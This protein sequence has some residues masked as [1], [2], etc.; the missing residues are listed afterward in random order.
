M[1]LAERPPV[2]RIGPGIHA[3]VV[4][5]RPSP[6][7]SSGVAVLVIL[8]AASMAACSPTVSP[9]SDVSPSGTGTLPSSAAATAPP[10]PG[11]ELYG[12]VPYWEMDD[13][14]AAHLAATPLTTLALF[15]VTHTSKGALSTS[16]NGYRRMTSALG[17]Q[18]IREAHDR[19]TRVELVYSSFGATRNRKLLES[20]SLQ[21]RVIESLVGLVDDLGADGVNV[22]IETLDPILV[23]A[24]GSFVGQLRAAIRAADPDHRVTAATAAGPLGAA[25]AVAAA[26]AGADRIFLMGYDYRVASSSPGATAPLE[27][28][29]G[30]TRDLRW[31][32]DLYAALGVPADRLLLGLP[33][34]GITW[35]VAGPVVGAP[36]TGRGDAWVPRRHLDLLLGAGAGTAVLDP[37]E[38]VDVYFTASDGTVGPPSAGASAATGASDRTWTAVYVDSPETLAVKLALANDGGLAGAGFWAVGYERGLPGYTALMTSFVRGDTL[39]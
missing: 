13:G 3:W 16:Q 1:V 29:D 24:Y 18:V 8:L 7:P 30:G 33:L 31:S 27:R 38:Q 23:P 36:S 15:S 39:P 19:G 35:P 9:S 2:D 4:H 20:A 12:F 32:L 25:M 34:Y 6:R 5:D 26:E 14:I 22:D 11:H 28:S 17:T 37:V 21:A 10:A